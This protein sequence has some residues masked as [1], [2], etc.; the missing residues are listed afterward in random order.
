[1]PRVNAYSRHSTCESVP[2]GESIFAS[3]IP[4]YRERLAWETLAKRVHELGTL[5]AAL[6]GAS[7]SKTQLVLQRRIQATENNRQSW[8][9]YLDNLAPKVRRATIQP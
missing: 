5:R 7:G 6:A 9:N 1:M 2:Q 3:S 8:V 4:E